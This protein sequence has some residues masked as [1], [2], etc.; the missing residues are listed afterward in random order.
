M[1][2]LVNR[3]REGDSHAFSKLYNIYFNRAY[4]TAFKIVRD[5]SAAEEV[6]QES[7]LR[8]LT[9]LDTLR[10]TK[11]F[12]SWFFSIVYRQSRY[13]IR[14]NMTPAPTVAL[15]TLREDS[16]EI[17]TVLDTEFLPAEALETKEDRELLLR[18]IDDLPDAQRIALVL[19]YYDEL[20]APEISEVLAVSA[21]TV[22]KRLYD[23]RASLKA[24]FSHATRIANYQ[25]DSQSE[26]L[27]VSQLLQSEVPA[28][29]VE[30]VRERTDARMAALLPTLLSTPVANK[31]LASR[32][33]AFLEGGRNTATGGKALAGAGKL[34]A[35]LSTKVVCL[36][37]AT[38]VV[39]AGAG[40]GYALHHLASR[41][42]AAPRAAAAATSGAQQATQQAAESSP[43]AQQKLAARDTTSVTQPAKEAT[44]AVATAALPAAA[45]SVPVASSPIIILAHPTLTY[46][47]GTA[48]DAA[49]I[50]ADCKASLQSQAGKEISVRVSGLD[51][52]DF[53]TPGAYHLYLHATDSAGNQIETAVIRI[54][55]E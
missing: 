2:E 12:E 6:V 46:A 9:N 13:W 41:Q 20:S 16:D 14:E 52:I 53:K 34:G 22:N 54:Q 4:Y 31:A 17:P 37:A 40:V 38:V 26:T 35:Q 3:A 55:I 49:R 32:A 8:L 36:A 11:R 50:M 51:L 10:E 7:F 25:I 44:T 27:V 21:P 5:E 48:I 33:Q 19:H 24:G 30:Q 1:I 29:R 39:A 42:Q 28:K 47:A 23:A 43:A 45:A 15:D 18:L